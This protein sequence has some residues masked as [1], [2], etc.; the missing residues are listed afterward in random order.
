MRMTRMQAGA[1]LVLNKISGAPGFRIDNVIV[2]AGIPQVM[3]MP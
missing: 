3:H 1:E 2:I